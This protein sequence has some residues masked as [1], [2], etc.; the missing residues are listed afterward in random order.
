[1]VTVRGAIE[2]LLVVLGVVV[3]D[4]GAMRVLASSM[5]AKLWG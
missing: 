5:E 1:M 4:E 2:R 3:V